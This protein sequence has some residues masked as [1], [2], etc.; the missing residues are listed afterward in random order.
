M[1]GISVSDQ[2]T[3]SGCGIQV[4]TENETL[5]GYAPKSALA[6]PVIICQ[7]CFRLTHYNEVPDVPFDNE[8]FVALLKTIGNEDALVVYIVDI[9][10]FNGSWVPGIKKYIGNNDVI[11]VGNK[12]DILPKSTNLRKLDQWLRTMSKSLGLNPV[13]V[14]LISAEK[15]LGIEELAEQIDQK[16]KGKDVYV[17]GCTNVGKSTFINRLIETFGGSEE[18]KITTSRFPGTT[19]NFIDIPLNEE[20]TLFDTPGVMNPHQMAHF[21]EKEALKVVMPK[22]ELKPKVYQLNEEQTLFFG[23]LVRLDYVSGGRRSL[24]CY[25]SNDLYIHRTKMSQADDLLKKQIGELLVPPYDP[26]AKPELK[27]HDI[28]LGEENMDVVISGLGWVTIKGEKGAKVRVYAPKG[29]GVTK[30]SSIIG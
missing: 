5:P 18:L 22:K 27:S 13:D 26:N 21:I 6:R 16:R 23:G 4:Q 19:L 20:N 8:D 28:A 7:R 9:F 24:V 17:V 30:R 25:I 15:G 11:L 2:L 3:C 10:D 12:L 1:G 14:A 29:V